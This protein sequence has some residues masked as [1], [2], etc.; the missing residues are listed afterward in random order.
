M[1][2]QYLLIALLCAAYWSLPAQQDTSARFHAG[3]E[4][5]A[6]PYAT[7]GYFAAIWAG[8]DKWR[9]RALT[10]VVY[11]PEWS[12]P[13]GFANHRITAYALVLDRFLKPGWRGWWIG[14]GPV[15]WQSKIQTDA[16]TQTAMF[17]DILLNGSMGYNIRLPYHFYLSPW[18]GLSLRVAGDKNVPVGD[19]MFTLPLLNP[20]A[21]LKLGWYF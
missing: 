12:T 3:A 13:S 2:K 19:K 5:D 21:S 18:A 14:G 7:G 15:F 8:K 16:E 20:E 17:D 6:L 11:K 1:N 9:L 4:L 10:A